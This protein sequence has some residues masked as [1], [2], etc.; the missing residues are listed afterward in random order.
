MVKENLRYSINWLDRFTYFAMS[1]PFYS[2]TCSFN[3]M[4]IGAK[5]GTNVNAFIP[6]ACNV[7]ILKKITYSIK[8]IFEVF[9]GVNKF[10]SKNKPVKYKIPKTNPLNIK[11]IKGFLTHFNVSLY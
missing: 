6:V 5:K 11:S 7:N 1:I 4:I 8:L 10:N 3:A 9:R 2:K